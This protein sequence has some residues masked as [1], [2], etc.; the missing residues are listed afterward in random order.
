MM[1][2]GNFGLAGLLTGDTDAAGRAFREEL[3]LCRELVVLPFA[4]EGLLG[5]AAV[6]TVRGDDDR[7][8]RLSGAASAHLYG[9]PEDDPVPGRLDMAFFEAART[10]HGPDAWEAAAREGRALSFEDAI[11]YALTGAPA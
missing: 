2:R 7:A 4:S 1:L 6:A 8:A 9:E 10:R 11:S 5:L 3:E